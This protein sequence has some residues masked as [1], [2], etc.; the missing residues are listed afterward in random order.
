M[1]INAELVHIGLSIDFY[2]SW[3]LVPINVTV[4]NVSPAFPPVITPLLVG[5]CLH[6]T[7]VLCR[8]LYC[9]SAAQLQSL[10]RAFS[11]VLPF[12]PSSHLLCLP[13]PP[14]LLPT[15]T[16]PDL[17]PYPLVMLS[18]CLLPQATHVW[19]RRLLSWAR[20]SCMCWS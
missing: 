7:S 10:S 3:F 19:T 13:A 5:H 20:R 1:S 17:I 6:S 4:C 11:T 9:W 16:Q 8:H 2:P 18:L 15:H 12:C 14:T